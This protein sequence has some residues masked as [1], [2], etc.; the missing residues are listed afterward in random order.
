MGKQE[1]FE[2][3]AVS[4]RV[5]VR[6]GRYGDLRAAVARSDQDKLGGK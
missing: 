6:I 5:E 2:A 4:V 1:I 3:Q